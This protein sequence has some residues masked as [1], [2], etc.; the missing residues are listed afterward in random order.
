MLCP[1]SKW[2]G[3]NTLIISTRLFFFSCLLSFA[4][5]VSCFHCMEIFLRQSP[6]MTVANRQKQLP[7]QQVRHHRPNQQV[8]SLSVAW[9]NSSTKDKLRLVKY[10]TVSP[11]HD[12]QTDDTSQACDS[13]RSYHRFHDNRHQRSIPLSAA[14]SIHAPKTIIITGASAV[15]DQIISTYKWLWIPKGKKQKPLSWKGNTQYF[16][17]VEE[18]GCGSEPRSSSYRSL[19]RLRSLETNRL[20][21]V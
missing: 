21:T 16:W 11:P 1:F 12:A 7:H 9:R 19:W 3:L 6:R 10:A 18:K 14:C 17:S 2:R 4:F 15:T 8:I 5:C 13:S 20:R